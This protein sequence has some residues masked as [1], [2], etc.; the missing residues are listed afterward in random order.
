VIWRVFKKLSQSNSRFNA[1]DT[2]VVTVYSVKI[3]ATRIDLSKGAVIPKLVRFQEYIRD[4]KI[5]VYQVLS[6]EDVMFEGQVV[7]ANR[8]NLLYNEVERHYHVITNLI[9]A[10]AK[11]YVRKA[12]QKDCTRKI[13]RVCVQTSSDCMVSPP[14]AISD[15]R[16]P[17]AECNRHLKAT[18][19][20]T[21]TS[22][23]LYRNILCACVW[24]A[25]THGNHE[26]NKRFFENCKQNRDVDH[27]CYIRPLKDVLHS[28]G[29]KVLHVFYDFET[30]Q[31][32]SYADKANYTYITLSV[33]NNSAHS[34]KTRKTES[35]CDA[36]NGST[37][38]VM[39]LSG[40]G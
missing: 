6:C 40:T 2:L 8:L 15:L 25:L 18:H 19:I 1:L 7:F 36:A 31:N 23:A 17:C 39:I 4:Y 32:T 28:A 22:K 21:T 37:R 29:D 12:C 20:I 34:A 14:S 38:S 10:V 27:L 9:G 3:E 33:S 35:T 13:T 24:M 16:I 26:F 5:V 30:T 11:K